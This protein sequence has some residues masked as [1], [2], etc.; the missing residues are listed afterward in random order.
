MVI[1]GEGVETA[2]NELI[3]FW[4]ENRDPKA[5]IGVV[6]GFDPSLNGM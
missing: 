2:T 1:N 4:N 5:S 6:Y 3:T